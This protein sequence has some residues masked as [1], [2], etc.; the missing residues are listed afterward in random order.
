MFGSRRPG[1]RSIV[2]TRVCAPYEGGFYRPGAIRSIKAGYPLPTYDVKFDEGGS[3]IFIETDLI[4][5]GF[6]SLTPGCLK[7]GQTV[8]ITHNGR[9]VKGCLL[10]KDSSERHM[11]GESQRV[12]LVG[13]GTDEKSTTLV[14]L[15][16]IRLIES[17][18][19]AR[20]VDQDTDY[21]K[22]A[23]LPNGECKK[24]TVTNCIEVPSAKHR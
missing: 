16:D 20:L 2:G 23:D 10:S 4:G 19:S 22:L 11:N 13:F 21:I 7:V 24:R 15:D 3:V 18:K 1:K 17:R 6:Q 9:E 8:Y 12:W 14:K 5:S